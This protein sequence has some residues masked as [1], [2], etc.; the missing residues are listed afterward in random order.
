M[1]KELKKIAYD[2]NVF[3]GIKSVEGHR[4]TDLDFNYMIEMIGVWR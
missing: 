4:P 2:Q 3:M 1:D